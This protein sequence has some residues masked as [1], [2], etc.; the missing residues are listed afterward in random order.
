MRARLA[1]EA[2]QCA[3]RRHHDRLKDRPSLVRSEVSERCSRA[4]VVV[5]EACAVPSCAYRLEGTCLAV[6][7]VW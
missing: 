1:G 6:P 2:A 4:P 3:S 7:E 5:Q